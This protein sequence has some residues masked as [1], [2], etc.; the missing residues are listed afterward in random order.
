MDRDQ[1]G[2]TTQVKHFA[3]RRISDN[4]VIV[5]K[6]RWC[7]SFF[8]RLQ[9]LHFRRHVGLEDSLVIVESTDSTIQSSIHMLFVFTSIAAIWINHAGIVVDSKLAKPFRPLYV[10]REPARYVLEGPPDLLE[11]LSPGDE[12]RFESIEV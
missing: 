4:K 12:I 5:P 11:S 3:V 2:Q 9:G 10:P 7:D 8:S 1:I 6:A